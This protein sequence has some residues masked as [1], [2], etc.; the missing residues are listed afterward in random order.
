MSIRTWTFFILADI[1]LLEGTVP[2]I[3]MEGTRPLTGPALPNL[4]NAV[5]MFKVKTG[6]I[7]DFDVDFKI[8]TALKGWVGHAP[9]GRGALHIIIILTIHQFAILFNSVVIALI[10]SPTVFI[11]SSNSTP[12]AERQ[13]T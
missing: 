10:F 5:G 8:L 6:L 11:A 2:I 3:I 4:I 13:D 1:E 7:F 9:Q 12:R